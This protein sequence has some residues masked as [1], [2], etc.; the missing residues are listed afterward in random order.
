MKPWIEEW[1]ST[2][3]STNGRNEEPELRCAV[4]LHLGRLTRKGLLKEQIHPRFVVSVRGLRAKKELNL[5]KGN[6]KQ[7]PLTC[8]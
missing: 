7:R 2:G 1:D 3:G 5:R 8:L 6:K 4:T